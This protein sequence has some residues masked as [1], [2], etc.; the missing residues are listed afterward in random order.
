[1]KYYVV[2][3]WKRRG[4]FTSRD[5]CK[6]LVQWYADA[7]YK[8]FKTKEEAEKALQGSREEYYQTKEKVS[9]QTSDF[10]YEK[11]SIA[12]DAACSWNPGK[13]EYQGIDLQSGKYLFHEKYEIATNNIWEFL[14]LVHGLKFQKENKSDKAIYTDSKHAMKRV[15]EKG[16]KTKLEKNS[17]TN[18]VYKKIQEAEQRLKENTYTTQILKRPTSE[19]WEIPADFWRK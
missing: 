12:V 5:E 3:E 6:E 19:R 9:R 14:A 1:M 11:N 10:P 15:A 17:N 4:I 7:K 2:R 18:F 13:M 16:C 8:S